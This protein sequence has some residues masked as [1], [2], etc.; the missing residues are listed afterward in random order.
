MVASFC[1]VRSLSWP[2]HPPHGQ[3]GTRRIGGSAISCSAASTAA[4]LGCRNS[5]G[6]PGASFAGG[7]FI[8]GKDGATTVDIMTGVPVPDVHSMVVFEQANP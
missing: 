7:P 8:L 3:T 1:D 2:M 4:R 5:A 6:I